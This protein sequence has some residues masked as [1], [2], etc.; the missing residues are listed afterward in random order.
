MRRIAL[1]LG[2]VFAISTFSK[3]IKIKIRQG[4]AG[5]DP[6]RSWD[7]S[8]NIF[9]LEIGVTKYNCQDDG[10]DCPG[11]SSTSGIVHINNDG[12]ISDQSLGLVSTAVQRINEGDYNG[13]LSSAEAPQ[14]SLIMLEQLTISLA[15]MEVPPYDDQLIPYI[16]HLKA[17]K[18]GVYVFWNY[19]TERDA[20]FVIIER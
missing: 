10:D 4:L 11:I 20:L 5:Y 12:T 16:D 13:R 17:F 7:V 3:P 8:I 6:K 14:E 18:S 1:L 19:K 9:G 2:L 15:N